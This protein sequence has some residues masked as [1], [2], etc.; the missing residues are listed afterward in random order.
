MDCGLLVTAVFHTV[1]SLKYTTVRPGNLF[2]GRDGMGAL[3]RAK[4]QGRP[5]SFTEKHK[6][7]IIGF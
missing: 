4:C 1:H 6:H 3:K 5:H 7:T 2:C